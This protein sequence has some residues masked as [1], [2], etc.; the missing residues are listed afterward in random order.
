MARVIVSVAL[1]IGLAVGTTAAQDAGDHPLQAGDRIRIKTPSASGIAGTLVAADQ[2][3]LTV[4]LEG[5]DAG[6]RKYARSEIAKLEISRG[7]KRNVLQGALIGAGVGV[8]VDLVGTRGE[9]ENPC[10][11]GAC[12]ALPVLGA[13]AGALVGLVK[14]ER[15]ERVPTEEVRVVIVPV[16]RGV[17]VSLS[18]RF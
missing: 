18:F 7:K 12:V 14:T 17:R 4:A 2:V 8:I 11:Y 3:A 6:Q 9:D 5:R 1:V 16:R 13:A 15:W 10:D